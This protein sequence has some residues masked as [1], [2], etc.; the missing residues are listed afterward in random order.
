VNPL[1]YEYLRKLLKE[2]SG[3]VL[4]ADKQYLLESRLLPI[5]RQ[6]GFR[7]LGELV[8][9]MRSKGA[10]RVTTDVVEAM[11][12]NESFFLRDKIPFEHFRNTI[13]PALLAAPS[14]NKTIRIWCA[15]CSTGQEPYSL[16]MIVD[17]MRP[18][19]RGWD[20]EI[21]A[22]DFSSSV[23]ERAQAGSYTHFEVQRG[24]PIQLLLKHFTPDGERWQLSPSIRSMVKFEQ[25]NLLHAFNHLGRFDV[26]FCRN[27][28]IYFDRQT[29]IDLLARLAR[30]AHPHCYL[31]LGA[32]ES[33]V[34]LSDAW[35]IVPDKKGLSQPR[36]RALPDVA[37]PSLQP[38]MLPA[39]T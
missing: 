14:A 37:A 29:K 17:D 18:S 35:T 19:L 13:I 23:L 3:L 2:R 1:D 30:A 24:L 11:A 36:R 39:L 32:A 22:T 28:L 15:A 31:L 26:I 7:E 5:A 12:T 4:A 16:A 8:E 9:K 38:A 10:E 25:L 33:V 20:V 6:Q 27:V 21:L 34:G